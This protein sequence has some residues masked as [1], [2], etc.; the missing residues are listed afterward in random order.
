MF[1]SMADQLCS[2]AA[3][4]TSDREKHYEV[5]GIDTLSNGLSRPTRRSTVLA[6][7][8]FVESLAGLAILRIELQRFAVVPDGLIDAAGL[9]EGLAQADVPVGRFYGDPG[10]LSE[11]LFRSIIIYCR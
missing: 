1:S 7:L 5:R 2:T 3:S 4:L 9:H 8:R 10:I 11:G 6:F